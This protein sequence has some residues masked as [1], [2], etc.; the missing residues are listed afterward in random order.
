MSSHDDTKPGGLDAKN[1]GDLA[2]QFNIDNRLGASIAKASPEAQAEIQKQLELSS[3]TLE[4][5]AKWQQDNHAER[6]DKERTRLLDRYMNEPANRPNTQEAR[7]NDMKIIE[8]QAEKHVTQRE[9]SYQNN[10]RTFAKS[11]VYNILQNDRQQNQAQPQQG[12]DKADHQQE[13]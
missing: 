7:Q 4:K 9:E 5:S 1:A 10:F 6:V 3:Q 13:R 2:H 11:Q 8:E 12:H